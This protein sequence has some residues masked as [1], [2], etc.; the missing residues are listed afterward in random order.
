MRRDRISAVETAPSS[1]Y[2]PVC[3]LAVLTVRKHKLEGKNPIGAADLEWILPVT[4][5]V[6]NLI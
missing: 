5:K 2:K 3:A 6:L 1:D 4:M